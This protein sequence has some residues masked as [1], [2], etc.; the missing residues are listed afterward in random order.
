M[1][2]SSLPLAAGQWHDLSGLASA[3]GYCQLI[4]GSLPFY[5]TSS[6]IRLERNCGLPSLTRRCSL[7]E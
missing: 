2:G 6:S 3:G 1:Y 4:D 5:G 7:L